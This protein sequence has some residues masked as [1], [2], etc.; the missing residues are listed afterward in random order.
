[1]FDR[2]ELSYKTY[3]SNKGN[4]KPIVVADDKILLD[5]VMRTDPNPAIPAH[6]LALINMILKVRYQDDILLRM[7]VIVTVSTYYKL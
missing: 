5:G 1:M 7:I 4:K 3:I 2:L 6:N